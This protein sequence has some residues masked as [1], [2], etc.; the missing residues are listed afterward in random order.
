MARLLAG[1]VDPA[2]AAA[3]GTAANGRWLQRDTQLVALRTDDLVDDVFAV[4]LT[5][6]DDELFVGGEKLPVQEV[7]E[8]ASVDG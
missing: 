1:E 8:I 2:V 4:G 5:R 6:F 7:T 3:V